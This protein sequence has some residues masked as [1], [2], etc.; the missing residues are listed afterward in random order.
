MSNTSGLPTLLAHL[1]QENEVLKRLR[2]RNKGSYHKYIFCCLSSI[3]GSNKDPEVRKCAH[4]PA[5]SSIFQANCTF[6]QDL[7]EEEH[8]STREHHNRQAIMGHRSIH[9]NRQ[10]T[11]ATVQFI[12]SAIQVVFYFVLLNNLWS[13]ARSLAT[14]M[15]QKSAW[16]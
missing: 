14:P 1:S 9:H 3:A 13:P 12:V 11:W 4:C 16:T 7:S 8:Q 10:A 2:V 5:Q 15:E 6:G